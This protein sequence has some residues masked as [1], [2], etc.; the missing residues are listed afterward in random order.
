MSPAALGTSC[1]NTSLQAATPVMSGDEPGYEEGLTQ[2][3]PE[4]SDMKH[5]E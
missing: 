1:S 2:Y 3:F 5:S 4:N